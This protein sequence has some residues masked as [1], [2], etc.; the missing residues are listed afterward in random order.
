MNTVF[1]DKIFC[2]F[3]ILESERLLF[4]KFVKK[5]SEQLLQIRSN[6]QVMQF[7]D[8]NWLKNIKESGT[9]IKS[10]N[11]DYKHQKGLSWAIIQK[12]SNRLIGSFAYWRIIKTHGRAEIG[13]SIHPDFWGN[14][15]MTETFKTLIEFGFNTMK[16]HSIEANV[17]PQ[18]EKSIK[19]LERVGFKKEAHFRENFFFNNQYLDSYIYSLLESDKR[20]Y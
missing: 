19:L 17:N 11:W 13:Y 16:L 7:M 4:R 5:D 6:E 1:D 14:G 12:H 3:P 2:K 8:S 9:L 10:F 18:N 20:N 15:I